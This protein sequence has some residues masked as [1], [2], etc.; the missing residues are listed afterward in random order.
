VARLAQDI[1]AIQCFL[2]NSHDAWF[3]GN[4]KITTAVC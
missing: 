2:D 4:K 3:S 1:A